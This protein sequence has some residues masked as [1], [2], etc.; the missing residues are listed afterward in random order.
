M[1]PSACNSSKALRTP[2]SQS[3]VYRAIVE[4]LGYIL[5]PASSAM[6]HNSFSTALSGGLRVA[7]RART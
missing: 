3:P 5:P 2:R 6:M 7:S 1:Y 4:M